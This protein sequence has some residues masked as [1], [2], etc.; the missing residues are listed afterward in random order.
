MQK[1][2][3][4]LIGKVA[5]FELQL[6]DSN[7][8]YFVSTTCGANYTLRTNI[9]NNNPWGV[10]F[11]KKTLLEWWLHPASDPIFAQRVALLL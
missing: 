3:R 9:R 8:S 11:K 5:L 10:N 4:K 6:S 7:K 1:L 2:P